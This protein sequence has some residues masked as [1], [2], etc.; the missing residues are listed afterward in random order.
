MPQQ[1]MPPRTKAQ[2]A[3]AS[4]VVLLCLSGLAAYLTI[5]RLMESEKWVVHTYEV[6]A[7]LG[8]VDSAVADAGRARSGYVITG[9]ADILSDFES[10]APQIH[11]ALQHL[12]ELTEDNAQQQKLCERLEQLTAR[13]VALFRQSIELKKSAT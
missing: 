8:N 12:R 10:A 7:A 6:Q 3:F 9:G 4:A 2:V 13:S 5:V 1:T 11:R